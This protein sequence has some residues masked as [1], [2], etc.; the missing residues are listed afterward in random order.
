MSFVVKAV[1]GLVDVLVDVVRIVWD[2]IA[3][4]ILEQVFALIGIVGETI[5]TAQRI[6]VPVFEEYEGDLV[7]DATVRAI[8]KKNKS[9]TDFFP[10][11]MNEMFQTKAK[12]KRYYNYAERGSYVH[13]LPNMTISGV[14]L[15][16]D[17]LT[18][19]NNAVQIHHGAPTAIIDMHSGFLNSLD[20]FRN[21]LQSTHG[22][23]AY[24]NMLTDLDVYGVLRNDWVLGTVDYNVNSNNYTINISRQA[25]LTKFW[26]EGPSSAKETDSMLFTIS[27][28]RPVPA[29]KSVTV[30]LRYTGSLADGT[31]F[32]TADSV[33][34]PQ[35]STSTTITLIAAGSF[36]LAIS[37]IVNTG[38]V[39]EHVEISSPSSVSG[40]VTL[41]T[42]VDVPTNPSDPNSPTERV[43][44]E[45]TPVVRTETPT[46]SH[47]LTAANLKDTIV[48][49][50]Y[51][52]ERYLK[53][54]YYVVGASPS[55]YYYWYYN[56]SNGTYNISPSTETLDQLE[57]LPVVVL[58]KDGVF[59]DVDKSVPLYTTTRRLL[60]TL[61]FDID[62][63]IASIKSS[64]GFSEN[65]EDNTITD[66]YMNFAA[67]PS[68]TDKVISK[69]LYNSFRIIIVDNGLYSELGEYSATFTEGDINNA[70]VWTG[71]TFAQNLSGVVTTEDDF[72]HS[73][74]KTT[75]GTLLRIRHQHSPNA[76]N[77][78]T[79]SNLNT[80]TAIDYNGYH[81]VASTKLWDD[82]T[83]AVSTHF[84]MA[85]SWAVF[86]TLTAREQT[87]IYRSICRLDLYSLQVTHLEWYETAAFAQ[88]FNIVMIALAVFTLGQTLI[89]EGFLVALTELAVGFAIGELVVFVAEATGNAALAAAVG[90]IATLVT[91]NTGKTFDFGKALNSLDLT[92]AVTLFSENFSNAGSAIANKTIEELV[93]EGIDIQK[94]KEQFETEQKE[95]EESRFSTV[96][97]SEFLNSIK[98][99]EAQIVSAID[100]QY[101]FDDSF[102]YGM[103]GNY[104]DT[105]LQTGII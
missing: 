2:V 56:H 24:T 74:E 101:R 61:G 51:V 82:E 89:A 80:L 7:K 54:T 69:L 59:C 92:E 6:S 97:T 84:G 63:F 53:V 86:S 102:G 37:S 103:V 47:P 3:E 81:Q 12:V 85:I 83:N 44:E 76:Y 46:V 19:I 16:A 23:V 15:T 88:L 33:T 70:T 22:Y 95:L 32:D 21:T 62:Q 43:Y 39:F 34:I 64:P 1:K 57:M 79:V 99:L 67:M 93:E 38:G 72:I 104:F 50:P 66:S 14:T 87:A 65:S 20:H 42:Y 94:A 40:V 18:T 58:S 4:P 78:I 27:C 60:S 25:E 17:Q 48:G 13:G 77:E 71:H 30:N 31:P 75:E 52:S 5:V 11:Y 36:N 73:V 29:G 96:V 8:I 41:L 9:G 49:A 35:N 105:Q 55:E 28:N 91:F 10:N 68:N 98:S 26:V 100:S 90:F 45:Y